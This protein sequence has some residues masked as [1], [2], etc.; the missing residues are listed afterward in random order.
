MHVEIAPPPRRFRSG[1][2]QIGES[3]GRDDLHGASLKK[4][5]RPAKTGRL[6]LA[7]GYPRGQVAEVA[8]V[9]EEPS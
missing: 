2:G 6:F 7:T 9:V 4:K 1:S 3:L 8:V 5:R